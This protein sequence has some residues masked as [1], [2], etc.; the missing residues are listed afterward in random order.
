MLNS[1]EVVKEKNSISMKIS[2]KDKGKIK[3]SQMK[4]K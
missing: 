4:E 1:F 3:H 2:F